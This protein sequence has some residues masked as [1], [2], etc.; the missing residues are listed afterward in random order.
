MDDLGGTVVSRRAGSANCRCFMF[1]YIYMYSLFTY[2][3]F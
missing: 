3:N 1:V 2:D